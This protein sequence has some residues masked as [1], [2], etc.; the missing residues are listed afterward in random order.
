[1]QSLKIT[2]TYVGAFISCA[3]AGVALAGKPDPAASRVFEPNRPREDAIE[4]GPR[5]YRDASPVALQVIGDWVK[6]QAR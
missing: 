4:R 1:M 3:L 2:C 5:L 6:Q